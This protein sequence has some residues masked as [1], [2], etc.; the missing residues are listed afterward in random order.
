[1]PPARQQQQRDDGITPF[2]FEQFLGVQTA[3]S[4]AGVPDEQAYW[5]DGFMPLAPRNLRTLPGV[6]T[7]AYSAAGGKTIVCFYFYNIGATPYA[8]VFLSDGSL[9]QVNTATNV[10]TTILGPGSIINP[11]VTQ[12]GVGQYGQQYL[13]T[14]ANQTNGY[15]VWD[16]INSYTAG[17]LAPGVVLTNVGA[18]YA[19]APAVT[20]T[21]GHGSGAT[22]VATVAGGVV[23]NVAISNP[24]SGYLA[25]DSVSL[26]FTG[27]T[28]V[29]SGGTV[30][31]SLTHAVGGSGGS[32]GPLWSINTSGF[33]FPAPSIIAIGSGYGSLVAASFGT[34]AAGVSWFSGGIP[35]VVP[36]ETSGT[37]SAV[38]LSPASAN[39]NKLLNNN[40]NFVKT[41]QANTPAGGSLITL[42]NINNITVGMLAFD[43]TA[44]AVIPVRTSITG[45]GAVTLCT[46]SNPVTGAGVQSND[47]IV[48]DDPSTFPSITVNDTGFFYVSSV[49]IVNVGSG[50]GPNVGISVAG[51][52]APQSQAV[53]TPLLSGG[54]T[55][56]LV[57]VV[58]NSGG[59][60]GSNTPPT[61]TVTDSATTAAGTVQ[62][63]PFG[64]QGTA[65]ATYSGHVWVFNGNVFN[66]TAPGSVNNFA[67]SAGGGSQQSN[68]SYLKVGFTQGV[69]TNGFLFLV[70]DSSMDYISGVVT[71]GS[72][73]TTT[74]TQNN[75]DP[76]IGSSY[77]AAVTTL[78]ENILVANST[79]V[80]VS[81]G[82][83]FQKVSE[84]MDGVYNTVPASNF[85]TNPFNGFQL[86]AAK[87]TI[88]GK[89]V[90]LALVPIIDPVSGSQVNKLLMFRDK[91]LWWAS[92]QDVGLTFIQGQE[93]N[94]VF[95]AWGTD[96][97]N[98]FPLFNQ[99]STAFTKV[100]RSKY[101]D[102]PGGIEYV[103]AESRFLSVWNAT[104]TVSTTFTLTMD[105]VGIDPSSNTQYTNSASYTIPGPVGVGYFASPPQA[106]GQAGVLNGF[107]IIT[108]AA[109]MTLIVA[110]IAGEMVGERM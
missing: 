7:T 42:G 69:N 84:P 25:G 74:F 20:G 101:W 12:M 2:S 43:R 104:S 97:T 41:A 39:P 94:S 9:I 70:G 22:F 58:I 16:G 23:S 28:Q 95:T 92:Q 87:A 45:V 108:Q 31:A 105:G 8:A 36:T 53:L 96:G 76:E 3:T 107:T 44:P 55:G 61:T 26:V 77:P 46:L 79:G 33:H 35:G 24:G 1:M 60:Y 67:T 100:A 19:T 81:A 59:V 88:F 34:L 57:S 51:G 13:I 63:M 82:G 32:I 99:P 11:T 75:S 4:R 5:L 17:T 18:G 65:V 68:N 91:K 40:N 90:W 71:S 78:G 49:S 38:S 50:Y 6:G 54:S 27:G 83:T 73:A 21:G 85:N 10:A 64:I 52:G 62:L 103:K 109:D 86:S 15:W 30:S 72:V 93:I 48:F 47:A 80:F 56:S 29:G 37:L 106:V 102:E 89:R 14:V 98:L 110:K 66:F